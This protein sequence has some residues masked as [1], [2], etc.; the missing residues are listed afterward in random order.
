MVL[1]GFGIQGSDFEGGGRP[2][3]SSLAAEGVEFFGAKLQKH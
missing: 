1:A 2:P 3:G